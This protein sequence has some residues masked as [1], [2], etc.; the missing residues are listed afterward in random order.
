MICAV[1]GRREFV[2][3]YNSSLDADVQSSAEFVMRQ[4][5]VTAKPYT[6]MTNNVS[7]SYNRV[8]K[9]FQNW[10]VSNVCIQKICNFLSAV[11]FFPLCGNELRYCWAICATETE[12]ETMHNY[13]LS[14]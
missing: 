11:N 14:A 12:T 13:S 9:D 10:K 2:D 7:E 5:G 1:S 6:G 3:H 4:V 8:I